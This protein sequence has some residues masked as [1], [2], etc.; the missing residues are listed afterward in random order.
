MMDRRF[1]LKSIGALSASSLLAPNITHASQSRNTGFL[2]RSAERPNIFFIVVDTLRND[3]TSVAGYTRD[4]TPN[5]A[6]FAQT[7]CVFGN[8]YSAA[9]WTLP[10]FASIL[11]GMHA[12]N[13]NQ[14]RAIPV[15]KLEPP[16]V[17]ILPQKLGEVGYRTV[18]IQSNLLVQLLDDSFDENFMVSGQGAYHNPINNPT[19]DQMVIE[20]TQSW[21]NKEANRSLPFFMFLGLFGPHWR[22]YPHYPFFQKYLTDQ[23]FWTAPSVNSEF[24]IVDLG[25]WIS[26]D[27]LSNYL[28]EI[29]DEPEGGYFLDSRFYTAAY[30]TEIRYTDMQLGRLMRT[31][32]MKGLFDD[33]LIIVTAD[34]G[35][36]MV[37]HTPH[38]EHGQSLYNA[39]L[40][41]PLLIKLPR[42]TQQIDLSDRPVRLIDTLPTVF[43]Y[44]DLYAGDIDGKSLLPMIASGT[45]GAIDQTNRPILS[46][47]LKNNS[48][49]YI[50]VIL[51]GFKLI[52]NQ[53]QDSDILFDLN[54]DPAEQVDVSDSYP[55]M[56]TM[57]R[58][59]LSNY[60]G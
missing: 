53:S 32:K 26:Y 2:S 14:N 59:Y 57:L 20:Q 17:T 52:R 27:S 12:F 33:S 35:E 42:Q 43:D 15:D 1:F 8:T 51:H 9:P 55:E 18:S 36:H 60:Y 40:R 45:V 29:F 6:Q 11:S 38:F 5:L 13:H 21:L 41:V 49:R 3:H 10:S 46:Y 44:L 56:V 28:K 37:D 7:A 25:G 16:N 23:T 58:D 4:T 22:F 54:S 24:R 39:L 48:Q 50:S 30:D 47:W 34:H 31:L 19:I